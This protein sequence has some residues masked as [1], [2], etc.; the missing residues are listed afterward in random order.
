MI[1]EEIIL[2]QAS[3]PTRD[4]GMRPTCIAFALTEVELM[5]A[6]GMQ[7]LSPEY[8][9]QSAARKTPGWVPHAGVPL[10]AALTAATD[11]QPTEADYPYQIIE[12]TAP[13]PPLPNSFP[14]YGLP[15]QC[16]PTDIA[17]IIRTLRSGAPIGLGLQ[18]TESFYR[19][20]NGIITFEA[21]VWP[22]ELHAVTVVGLGWE[23]S[24]PYFLV[25]NSWGTGWG[26]QGNAWLPA[27]Y[28]QA[29]VLCIFG[30]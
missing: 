29:H 25:R 22:D 10:G 11:G 28:V 13:I 9:Y 12:P 17:Q 7:A 2:Q 15:V 27:A 16:Y 19:P 23:H 8:L 26:I 14:L 4:Q 6:P 1:K 21:N 3:N 30:A 20:V 18:L 24:D 5:A